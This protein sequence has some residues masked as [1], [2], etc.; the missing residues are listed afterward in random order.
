MWRVIANSLIRK[1][2]QFLRNC[3]TSTSQGY[4]L[5]M[6]ALEKKR[7]SSR[8]N[9]MPISKIFSAIGN[10]R[11]KKSL[12][13]K[14]KNRG[15]VKALSHFLRS[16]SVHLQWR[17]ILLKRSVRDTLVSPLNTGM[18]TCH[19]VQN[20]TSL[21][22]WSKGLRWNQWWAKRFLTVNQLFLKNVCIRNR[23][24]NR[25]QRQTLNK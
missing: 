2:R 20:Q 19:Q 18:Q 22:L 8:R 21:S 1:A 4:T 14:R 6:W 10:H 17:L 12:R 23:K 25:R 11:T 15:L 7:S 24:L 3:R 13:N 9:Q 5:S 16:W